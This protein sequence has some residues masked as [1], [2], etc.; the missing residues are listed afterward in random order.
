MLEPIPCPRVTIMRK[1]GL[2]PDPWQI[3]VLESEHP[4]LLLNCCRQAGKT[5]VV[6]ILGLLKA[7]F[8]PM[9]RVLLVSR[10]H[11]QSKELLRQM[12][13][14]HDLLG[15]RLL[16]R[17]TN[18]VLEFTNLSRIVSM[19]CRE[20]TIRGFAHVDLLV[21]DEAARVPADL[22][23]AVRPM[24]AVSKGRLIC[25]STP[26]G[27]RGFFWEAWA[28]GGND[29]HRI[30]IPATKI[31]RISP[32]F[33]DEERRTHGDAFFRQEYECSFESVEGLVYPDFARC[34]VPRASSQWSIVNRQWQR[35]LRRWERTYG[36]RAVAFQ[37]RLA[38]PVADD[39]TATDDRPRTMDHRLLT[40]DNFECIGGIDFGFR[41]PFAAIWGFVDRDDVL[42]LVGEH[43]AQEKPLSHHAQFLPKHVTWYADPSGASEICELRCA[44]FV[45]RRGNNAISA[46][47][48]A[49]A[50]RV[51]AGKLKIL[52][53]AC[54]QLLAE[55][56]LYR[57]AERGETSRNGEAPQDDHN[58]ALGALR[59]LVSRLD[60]RRMALG[61]EGDWPRDGFPRFSR[62]VHG[63]SRGAVVGLLAVPLERHFQ[64][65][66]A[67]RSN[68]KP[69]TA[70]RVSARAIWIGSAITFAIM[71]NGDWLRRSSEEHLNSEADGG[72]CPHFFT[73]QSAAA[74]A[75]KSKAGWN[76]SRCPKARLKPNRAKSRERG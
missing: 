68:G 13:F 62:P 19:P 47:I 14:F 42:W 35:N 64:E 33:L 11:R 48:A 54:P 56:G 4:R 25:L 63:P 60:E 41:N 18:E 45:V 58:H 51:S 29:W 71:K 5:T 66:K 23:R 44:D 40:T 2:E 49:V 36:R 74:P 57:W 50:A 21:I 16:Q 8:S 38:E 27:R 65:Q 31:P 39:E 9:T 34:V 17:K 28:K 37:P 3:D 67:T 59:Y 26:H 12:Q 30:E 20:E 15:S 43:Y 52:E 69:A 22:Y 6:A 46:G 72:A 55:A 24:L 75:A 76:E 7:M 53:G 10:S 70:S 61:R 1:L 32:E 73:A